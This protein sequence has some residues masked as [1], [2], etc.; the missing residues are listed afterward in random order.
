[1]TWTPSAGSPCS[2]GLP[3]TL[4][5][6]IWGGCRLA[7]ERLGDVSGPPALALLCAW[8]PDAAVL[9]SEWLLHGDAL[10]EARSRWVARAPLQANSCA[11]GRGLP[12]DRARSLGPDH[13][14]RDGW[15]RVRRSEQR[16]ESL[17]GCRCRRSRGGGA[18]RREWLGSGR[19][20]P[21][22]RQTPLAWAV[23]HN[24]PD[25]VEYLVGAG[26]DPDAPS[27][28]GQDTPLHAAAFF[29]RF[30][31]ADLLLDGGADAN[32]CNQLGATPRDALR[33]G[34]ERVGT[35]ASM[36]G[37]EID[38]GEV[39]RGR[40]QLQEAFDTRGAVSGRTMCDAGV[41]SAGGGAPPS[42][43]RTHFAG[44]VLMGLMYVPALHHLWFLCVLCWL[45][46]GFAISQQCFRHWCG[47]SASR[48]GLRA[49]RS[50][51][52]GLFRSRPPLSP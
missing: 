22:F 48:R 13:R 14:I 35:V 1:M 3:C 47:A 20:R 17:V 18:V 16:P 38:F 11:L 6:P 37:V 45:I 49:P 36:L 41:A 24:H 5:W 50:R 42:D 44:N 39:V 8:I 10:A 25:V 28:R 4:P 26:A 43:S 27:G 51:C 34:E 31:C 12:D 23:H 32:A 29:G 30:E 46:A 33:H 2:S 7:G 40:E 21:L 52:F 15:C 19:D 9:R